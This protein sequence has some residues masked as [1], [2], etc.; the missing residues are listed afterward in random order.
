MSEDPRIEQVKAFK[1][2]DVVGKVSHPHHAVWRFRPASA[3]VS[4]PWS[5]VSEMSD[6]E[7]VDPE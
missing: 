6:D 4:K 1:T 5:I 2:G 7:A 3:Q